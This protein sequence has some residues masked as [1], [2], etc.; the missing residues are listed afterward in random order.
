[1]TGRGKPNCILCSLRARLHGSRNQE[2]EGWQTKPKGAPWDTG[3][4]RQRDAWLSC[5]KREPTWTHCWK[6]SL[7]LRL[8][9]S[10]SSCPDP[11]PSRWRAFWGPLTRRRSAA[12]TGQFAN[13]G[14]NH[15]ST[16]K[17]SHNSHWNNFRKA[18]R[19]AAGTENHY[20]P[21]LN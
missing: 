10:C 21:G 16:R 11:E 5:E 3:N 4:K 12:M 14:G 6:K 1:M 19:E 13:H 8:L 2:E 20:R 15:K 18:F 7:E 17:W 9:V